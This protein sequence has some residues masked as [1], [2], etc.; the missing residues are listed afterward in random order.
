[1][2]LNNRLKLSRL[3]GNYVAG[4]LSQSGDTRKFLFANST[5]KAFDGSKDIAA[6]QCWLECDIAQANELA[7]YFSNPTGIESITSTPQGK[8]AGIYDIAGKKLDTPQKVINII[9][10]KKVLVK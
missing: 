8:S 3:N 1:M 5:F 7:V 9:D 10:S 2:P 4:S 6:N